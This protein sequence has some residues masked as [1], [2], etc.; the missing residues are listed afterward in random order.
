MNFS[1]LKLK[2]IQNTTKTNL[3]LEFIENLTQIIMKNY[4]R[5][6]V[7]HPAEDLAVIM[8][9]YGYYEKLWQFSSF[10]LSKGFN[11]LEISGAD[12]FLDGN[13]TKSEPLADTLI[14][15]ASHTGLP[16]KTTFE[17]NGVTYHAVKVADKIYI[18]DK[19][20]TV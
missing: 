16:I 11:V 6:T 3:H 19:N 4:F 1:I 14:L 20:K 12:K 9:S 7:Y 10:F 18:P 17:H 15:R 13:I 2:K 5:I 8:D